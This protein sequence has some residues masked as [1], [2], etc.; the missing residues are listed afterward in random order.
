MRVSNST[1][2]LW[3]G[4]DWAMVSFWQ[5]KLTML[6]SLHILRL[7]HQKCIL[8]TFSDLC[9]KEQSTTEFSTFVS[10]ITSARVNQHILTFRD[11]PRSRSHHSN[12]ADAADASRSVQ[13]WEVNP[14]TD[15]FWDMTC[16]Q[17]G[18]GAGFC[19]FS[20]QGQNLK[21]Y[22]FKSRIFVQVMWTWMLVYYS[23]R[24]KNDSSHQNPSAIHTHNYTI[25]LNK[26]CFYSKHDAI[27]QF[28]VHLYSVTPSVSPTYIQQLL[29]CHFCHWINIVEKYWQLNSVLLVE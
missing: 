24:N 4:G 26:I 18:G 13:W 28:W 29:H 15:M 9:H 14:T 23:W 12:A 10:A 5:S 1:E 25:N 3:P 21:Q 7:S 19:T 11:G 17:A 27:V 6:L 16:S 8:T 22:S 20:M 2:A